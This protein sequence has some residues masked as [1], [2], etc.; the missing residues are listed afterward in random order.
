M[1]VFRSTEREIIQCKEQGFVPIAVVGTAATTVLA[2][3]DPFNEI[4]DVCQ[5]HGVWFHIDGFL[6]LSFSLFPIVLI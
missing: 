5:R 2:T 4:A 3:F 6:P 1:T